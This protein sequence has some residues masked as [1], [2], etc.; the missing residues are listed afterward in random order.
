M[1]YSIYV[2]YNLS[3]HLN[4]TDDLDDRIQQIFCDSE[5]EF[6]GTDM[7]FGPEPTRG[8]FFYTDN[9]DKADKFSIAA[10]LLADDITI[11]ITKDDEVF[12]VE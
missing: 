11:V 7:G 12:E 1:M 3:K 10:K 6:D 9:K 4:D 8:L 5:I 2:E